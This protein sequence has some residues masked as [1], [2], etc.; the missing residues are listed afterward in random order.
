MEIGFL[1]PFSTIF[2][3]YFYTMEEVRVLQCIAFI[4]N[5][6]VIFII[7]IIIIIIIIYIII[8]L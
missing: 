6:I 7:I 1:Q 3:K 8:R 5:I 2:P 4:D